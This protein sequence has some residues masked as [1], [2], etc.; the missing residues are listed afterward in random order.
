[1]FVLSPQLSPPSLPTFAFGFC[2]YKLFFQDLGASTNIDNGS[3]TLHTESFRKALQQHP[4][5][6][7]VM[8]PSQT[9]HITDNQQ[10]SYHETKGGTTKQIIYLKKKKTHRK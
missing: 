5:L 1:M 2:R 3:K 9:A 8:M 7:N 6:L 10:L 4:G